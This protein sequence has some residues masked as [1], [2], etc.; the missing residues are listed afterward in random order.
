MKKVTKPDLNFGGQNHELWYEGGEERFVL[1]MV[2]QSKYFAESCFWFSSLISKKS[3]LK[4]VYKVLK[5][6][7]ATEVETIPMGQGN[8][9]SRIVAWTFLNKEKQKQWK[10][11]RWKNL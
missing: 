6:Y 9:T 2:R 7:G 4:G 10:D 3:N 11:K 5:K 1:R 8:K